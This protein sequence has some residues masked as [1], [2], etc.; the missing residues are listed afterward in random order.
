MSLRFRYRAAGFRHLPYALYVP[1][2]A[3]PPQGWPLVLFLHGSL[4]RGS[5][6]KLAA[7]VGLGPALRA[8]P[9]RWPV[10]AVMPQCPPG[11]LWE[12]QALEGA[13]H[14]LQ[15]VRQSWPINHRRIYLTGVSM[16]GAG[17]WRM[18]L[19]Y[20]ELFAAVVPM[21]GAA[22][23]FAVMN[24]PHRLPIWNFHGLQ[25][26][27]VPVEFSRVLQQALVMGR[28]R[29]HRFSEVQGADHLVWEVAYQDPELP[30]WLLAQQQPQ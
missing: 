8:H 20:P 5:D 1:Q 13:Y 11:L 24:L 22:D 7:K 2:G 28:H 26:R 21:C 25:D 18:A 19:K 29:N 30:S 15:Q 10:V 4:E 6:G 27:V 14:S 9:Q 12:E 16:G 23:P 3:A 17:A